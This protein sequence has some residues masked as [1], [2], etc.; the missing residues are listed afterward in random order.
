MLKQLGALH[1]KGTTI[2]PMKK[3][4]QLLAGSHRG[5]VGDAN[6]AMYFIHNGL[7]GW[8]A[9]S[10]WH[11]YRYPQS[12]GLVQIRFSVEK[13]WWFLGEPYQISEMYIYLWTPKPSNMM[14]LIPRIWVITYRKEGCR[15]P[16]YIPRTLWW[17]LFLK[18]QNP[19]K[20]G[21]NSNQSKVIWLPGIYMYREIYINR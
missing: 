13:K 8:P 14:D 4:W 17:P 19:P 3:G 12:E 21:R 9:P 18:G 2:F 20:Q 7:S 1:P 10:N 6:V 11:S 5:R 16:W 15:L